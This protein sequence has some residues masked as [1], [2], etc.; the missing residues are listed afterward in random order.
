M[1]GVSGGGTN[2]DMQ[3]SARRAQ[4]D[5][6]NQRDPVEKVLPWAALVIAGI[7]LLLMILL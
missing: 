1:A 7:V 4:G 6:N 5:P 3:Q 2:S